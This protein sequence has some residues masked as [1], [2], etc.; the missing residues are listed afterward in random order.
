MDRIKDMLVETIEDFRNEVCYD[1]R[2]ENVFDELLVNNDRHKII[3]KGDIK[4]FISKAIENCDREIA[5]E[6]DSYIDG[7]YDELCT[8]TLSLYINLKKDL[9]KLQN[10]LNENEKNII[11]PK[12]V[13]LFNE[14]Y[15]IVENYI[16]DE[17][18]LELDSLNEWHTIFTLDDG[19]VEIETL[20]ECIDG[21]IDFA[22]QLSKDNINLGEFETAQVC[23]GD[24]IK[25]KALKE[26]VKKATESPYV[27][28]LKKF[29]SD[30]E[31]IVDKVHDSY[32][33]EE[34]DYTFLPKLEIKIDNKE[35][36]LEFGADIYSNLCEM[37]NF[38][39][40][41]YTNINK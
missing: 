29:R 38:E 34:G 23:L 31:T 24:V 30:L 4:S 6:Q 12:S 8:E 25:L 41:E 21:Y 10:E 18:T 39:L 3:I 9:I 17:Q 27:A 20:E 15:E 16:L 7:D 28:Q 26:K 22:A 37:I 19:S 11:D 33:E 1:C 35:C 5:F 13:E 32:D 40:R 2:F 14:L 36:Y